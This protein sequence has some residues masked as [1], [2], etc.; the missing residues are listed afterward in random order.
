MICFCQFPVVLFYTGNLYICVFMT[1]SISYSVCG[2]QD[3]GMC[4]C[5]YVYMYV[6]VCVCV[7]VCVYVP[8]YALPVIQA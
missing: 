2:T 8:T 3:R 1:Y 7:C 4:V 5:M 6:F